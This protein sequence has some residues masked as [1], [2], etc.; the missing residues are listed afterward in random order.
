[1]LTSKFDAFTFTDSVPVTM[2]ESS[3]SHIIV[4]D[5]IY[6]IISTKSNNIKINYDI[7]ITFRNVP[8]YLRTNVTNT[9]KMI[10]FSISILC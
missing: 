3:P 7:N 8:A 9:W 6:S 4:V 10:R 1:M 5:F 2:I